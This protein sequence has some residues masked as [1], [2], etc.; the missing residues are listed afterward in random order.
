[1]KSFLIHDDLFL[2]GKGRLEK[3]IELYKESG[4]NA[5][6]Y[7]QGRADLIIKYQKQIKNL[8]HIGLKGI[9]IGFESG[10]DRILKFIN[11]DVTVEEN[12]ESAKI[13]KD[14][15][16]KIWANYMF[17]LPGE[18]FIEMIKTS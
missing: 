10:S 7:I 9:L 3:F 15:G 1:L 11:K 12:L 13:C 17:G 16:I 14:L 5:E 2:M 18:S 8:S 6:F 4:I